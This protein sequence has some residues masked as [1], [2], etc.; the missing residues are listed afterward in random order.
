MGK[1]LLVPGFLAQHP[2]FQ[3]GGDKT[4]VSIEIQIIDWGWPIVQVIDNI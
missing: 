4:K 2:E 3:Q 1:V